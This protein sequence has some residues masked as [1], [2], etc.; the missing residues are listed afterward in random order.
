MIDM[1]RWEELAAAGYMPGPRPRACSR[2][3]WPS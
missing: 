2:A 3:S 1:K